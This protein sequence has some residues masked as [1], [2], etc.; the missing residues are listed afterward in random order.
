MLA[1]DNSGRQV[2]DVALNSNI[3]GARMHRTS[4]FKDNGLLESLDDKLS[5]R[6]DLS[7]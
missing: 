2:H 4:Y 5:L 3:T 6:T 7:G 1:T